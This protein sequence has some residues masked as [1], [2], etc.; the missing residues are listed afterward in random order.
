M[1]SIGIIGDVHGKFDE[2]YNLIKRSGSKETIQIGDMG[3]GFSK[4]YD[5]LLEDYYNDLSSDPGSS[6]RFFRGNHDSP[7]VCNRHPNYMGDFGYEEDTG[8]FWVGGAWS[9]DYAHRTNGV[10]I[11]ENEE[12]DDVQWKEVIKLYIEK[13]PDIVLSH[14][15]PLELYSS[16]LGY[17]GSRIFPT[18]TSRKLNELLNIHVPNR[19][20]YGHHHLSITHE[21]LGCEFRC[22][23][24]LEMYELRI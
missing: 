8:I 1:R 6:H 5:N 2:Y 24:E 10:D 20:V 9:I 14:D 13:K 16:M 15:C 18:K 17:Y 19:W 23:A 7:E 21:H 3:V 11:W 12:L 4:R 22:L